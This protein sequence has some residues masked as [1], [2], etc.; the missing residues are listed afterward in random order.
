MDDRKGEVVSLQINIDSL[1]VHP[2][3]SYFQVPTASV[4]RRSSDG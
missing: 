1:Y 4:V 3:S 2:G